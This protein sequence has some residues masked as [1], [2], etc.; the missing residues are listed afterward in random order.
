[1]LIVLMIISGCSLLTN[2][3]IKNDIDTSQDE[4]THQQDII[5]DETK[6]KQIVE[7]EAAKESA[8]DKIKIAED[9]AKDTRIL[10]DIHILSTHLVSIYI[11]EGKYPVNSKS[12]KAM[13][14]KTINPMKFLTEDKEDILYLSF[15]NGRWYAIIAPMYN[16]GNIQSTTIEHIVDVLES[17]NYSNIDKNNLQSLFSDWESFF[18]VNIN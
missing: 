17:T 10:V 11:D 16:K 7:I 13:H 6:N 4:A 14:I 2:E 18:Q 9:N 12:I 15:W 3:I 8:I 5:V 1:M